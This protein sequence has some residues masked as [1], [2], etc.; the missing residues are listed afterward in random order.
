MS[1]RPIVARAFELAPECSSLKELRRKL[2]Q[3]GYPLV[4]VE[5]YLSGL[6]IRR[7]LQKLYNGG[8]GAKKR[9][10]KPP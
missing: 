4:S 7:E 2:R 1:D 5:M 10:P 8:T 9:G 3:E 6:G